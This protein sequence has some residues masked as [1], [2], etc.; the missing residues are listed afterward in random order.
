MAWRRL[1]IAFNGFSVAVRKVARTRSQIRGLVGSRGISVGMVG[2]VGL[3]EMV[4]V[5]M[6][7]IGVTFWFV[8]DNPKVLGV[9]ATKNPDHI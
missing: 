6:G 4:G 8:F 5:V 3:M 9:S 1:A 2:C 7:C